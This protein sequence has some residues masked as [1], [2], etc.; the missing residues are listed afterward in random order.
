MWL[1]ECI[2]PAAHKLIGKERLEQ[3]T[4]N[5]S[6]KQSRIK[7]L[8]KKFAEIQT[9][10]LKAVAN[11]NFEEAAKYKRQKADIDVELKTLI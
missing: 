6:Q 7:E 4:T 3:L 9:A 10:L 8:E 2:L 1:S 11:E 5:K